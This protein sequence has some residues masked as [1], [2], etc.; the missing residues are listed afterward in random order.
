MR[1][2]ICIFVLERGRGK[3]LK[4][5]TKFVKDKMLSEENAPSAESVLVMW[6]I[7]EL[8]V[9]FWCTRR[10]RLR[11]RSSSLTR[12]SSYGGWKMYREKNLGK[13]FGNGECGG[14]LR[15]GWK[16][17]GI[18]RVVDLKLYGREWKWGCGL[19]WD[20]G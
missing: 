1:A 20:G 3:I 7:R 11:T 15:G 12:R 5:S 4:D 2:E 6:P 17:E 19:R 13:I 10:V 9:S 8:N 18:V 14:S 16:Q